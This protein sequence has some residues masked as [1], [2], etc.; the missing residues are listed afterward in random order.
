[1]FSAFKK[2]LFVGHQDIQL[3]HLVPIVCLRPTSDQS[4]DYCVIRKLD[5]GGVALGGGIV[6]GEEGVQ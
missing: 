5:D 1:M 3:S 6:V 2:W 4:N